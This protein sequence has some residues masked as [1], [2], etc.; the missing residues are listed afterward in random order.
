MLS[1]PVDTGGP[2]SG[3]ESDSCANGREGGS[4]LCTGVKTE[5]KTLQSLCTAPSVLRQ[6]NV[7]AVTVWGRQC[8]APAG[9][10]VQ[11]AQ[12]WAVWSSDVTSKETLLWSNPPSMKWGY[13]QPAAPSPGHSSTLQ[14]YLLRK[15]LFLQVRFENPKAVHSAA[16]M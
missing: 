12:S 14:H 6:D 3:T 16:A 4:I 9:H 7:R 11:E 5:N 2:Q 15:P 8:T 10:P 13:W 1:V